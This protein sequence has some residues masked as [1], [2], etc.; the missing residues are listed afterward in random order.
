MPACGGE[1]QPHMTLPSYIQKSF[2]WN[3]Y[4]RGHFFRHRRHSFRRR[5]SPS[6]K[7]PG[8]GAKLLPPREASDRQRPLHKLH[9]ILADF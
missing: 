3:W 1:R 9:R 8:K 5:S 7:L 6:A 4:N 2:A